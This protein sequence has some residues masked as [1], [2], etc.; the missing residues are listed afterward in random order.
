MVSPS[1]QSGFRVVSFSG[2]VS[3]VVSVEPSID[4]MPSSSSTSAMVG[5]PQLH[6]AV[7]S[8]LQG[9]ASVPSSSQRVV[10]VGTHSGGSE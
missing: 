2:S 1:T 4:Q 7:G 3:S 6:P 5:L 8:P 9:T 10:P